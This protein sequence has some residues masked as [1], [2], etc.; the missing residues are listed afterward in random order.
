M[1]F[2]CLVRNSIR[3]SQSLDVTFRSPVNQKWCENLIDSKLQKH[4]LTT[5]PKYLFPQ[6]LKELVN[7]LNLENMKS[8][9]KIFRIVALDPNEVLKK[10][11][12]NSE[13]IRFNVLYVNQ[14]QLKSVRKEDKLPSITSADVQVETDN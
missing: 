8:G 6:L 7:L 14:E 9:F 1:W 5:L 13:E 3:L 2:I 12:D 4:N 11:P 10:F